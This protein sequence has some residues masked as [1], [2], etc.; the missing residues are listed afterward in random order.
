[1]MHPLYRGSDGRLSV[2]LTK[3]Y[4]LAFDILDNGFP[5]PVDLEMSVRSQG[6]NVDHLYE[7]HDMP[8]PLA[9]PHPNDFN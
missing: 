9:L 8:R 1:M 2:G 6:Y 7:V 3:E 5:L 4:V